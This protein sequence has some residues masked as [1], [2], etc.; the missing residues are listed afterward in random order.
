MHVV[1]VSVGSWGDV[2]PYLA[3]A[4]EILTRNSSNKVDFFVQSQYESRVKQMTTLIGDNDN[5]D[6]SLQNHNPFHESN[7]LLHALP[8]STRDFYKVKPTTTS[9]PKLKHVETVAEIIGELVLPCAKWIHSILVTSTMT[10]T[11]TT[12]QEDD[13][14]ADLNNNKNNDTI[15]LSSALS[16][17]LCLLLARVLKIPMVLVH[18][19]PLAPNSIFPLYRV[20]PTNKCVQAM[21]MM[22]QQQQPQQEEENDSLSTTEYHHDYYYYEET[23]WKIDHPLEEIFLKDRLIAAYDQF[24][25]VPPTWSELQAILKGLDSGVRIV[26]C[27]SRHLI[28]SIAGTRGVGPNIHEI[29]SSLADNYL[30]WNYTPDPELDAFLQHWS[31]H[32]N[33]DDDDGR[34]RRGRATAATGP[35]CIG[36]GS[37]PFSE[38]SA[39]MDALLEL[40]MPAVLLGAPFQFRSCP[41][42]Y[43]DFVFGNTTAA[44]SK[45][46]V[47][48]E[49]APYAY[50]L[51]Q[52]SMMLCHG[53]AGVVHATLRAG[54]P[55]LIRPI[56]GDQ[57][58]FAS[59]LEQKGLGVQVIGKPNCQLIAP[60]DIVQAVR[61]VVS[62]SSPPPDSSTFSIPN[63]CQE[64]RQKI[65]NDEAIHSHGVVQ[66]AN[67]LE[68]V[69]AGT[70][71][72]SDTD[73]S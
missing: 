35:I 1:M 14:A 51:P 2:E 54:I 41:P 64:F 25:L 73:D 23:Y 37:M 12:T 40:D 3:L 31:G 38:L 45:K 61:Q 43:Q 59:L 63:N 62:S 32:R 65:L 70:S 17:P 9:N 18:L 47:R 27:F 67:L 48:I 46:I 7:F 6:S 71:P 68:R 60:E 24:G 39:I 21:M 69:V 26:N 33:N 42:Q 72:T 36:F 66:L 57:F 34:P 30:P 15:L 13:A 50:L 22:I 19:Q 8:F 4:Q 55:C 28:P 11:T 52:C 58:L 49:F 53:G 56:M 16:R 44:S 5:D 10:T 20:V 29:G